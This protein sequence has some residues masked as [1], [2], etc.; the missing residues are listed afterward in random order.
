[1]TLTIKSYQRW[2]IEP[3]SMQN[4]KFCK[5]L[6]YLFSP[7][8]KTRVFVFPK[9]LS[10]FINSYNKTMIKQAKMCSTLF[11]LHYLP[12]TGKTRVL[13]SKNFFIK[14]YKWS[15]VFMNLSTDLGEPFSLFVFFFEKKNVSAKKNMLVMNKKIFGPKQKLL[16]KKFKIFVKV[17]EQKKSL[18]KDFL[19]VKYFSLFRKN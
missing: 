9:I 17:F 15:R 5:I 16:R 19:F 8:K 14:F 7:S 6:D 18:A 12:R 1:M 10:S 13:A 2:A 11:F 4:S 3:W